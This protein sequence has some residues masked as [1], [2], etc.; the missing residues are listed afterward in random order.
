MSFYGHLILKE[1]QQFNMDIQDFDFSS[2][3]I[4][5]V[6]LLD[7]LS[8]TEIKEADFVYWEALL[9][10]PNY[11]FLPLFIYL[12]TAKI[13]IADFYNRYHLSLSEFT[14]SENFNFDKRPFDPVQAINEKMTLGRITGATIQ[15]SYNT[16][17]RQLTLIKRFNENN[18]SGT[19]DESLSNSILIEKEYQNITTEFGL[20][21]LSDF[22]LSEI[23]QRQIPIKQFLK[24]KQLRN[25][26]IL[27]K[28]M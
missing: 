20:I 12:L 27:E 24:E 17:K 23:K 3:D 28:G 26:A 25:L 11:I 4:T 7:L 18:P 21:T 1:R 5:P 16:E 9:L 13:S 8:Q 15:D 6:A 10:L 2:H 22:E 19:V 14:V